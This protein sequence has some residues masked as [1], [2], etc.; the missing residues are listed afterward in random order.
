MDGPSSKKIKKEDDEEQKKKEDIKKQN[1]KIFHYRDNLERSLKKNELQELLEYNK[2]EIP[3]GN[4]KVNVIQIF[5]SYFHKFITLID[6][7]ISFF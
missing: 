2:Q 4:D 5:I 6:A 7:K 3:T 1:K